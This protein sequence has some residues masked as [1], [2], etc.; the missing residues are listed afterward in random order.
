MRQ[1]EAPVY[2]C[3]LSTL[4]GVN[5]CP[6]EI[7][8]AHSVACCLRACMGNTPCKSPSWEQAQPRGGQVRP[9]MGPFRRQRALLPC[10]GSKDQAALLR[11]AFLI[12]L[13]MWALEELEENKVRIPRRKNSELAGEMLYF[14]LSQEGRDSRHLQSPFQQLM[15]SGGNMISWE[16]GIQCQVLPAVLLLHGELGSPFRN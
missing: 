10:P 4:L 12:S 3:G 2:L 9:A 8:N 7:Q 16:K 14:L 15:P 6:S 13:L 1:R 5:K 11:L